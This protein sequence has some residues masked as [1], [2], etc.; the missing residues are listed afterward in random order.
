MTSDELD[1]WA[2]AAEHMTVP[3]DDELG[4]L[5]QGLEDLLR[6]GPTLLDRDPA[7]RAR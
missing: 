2:R 3:F 7:A 6:H 1:T 5:A 4:V